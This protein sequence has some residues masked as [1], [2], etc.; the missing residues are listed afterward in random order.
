[1]NENAMILSA[2]ENRLKSRLSL[3]HHANKSSRQSG[4]L[5]LRP[6]LSDPAV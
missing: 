5:L 3:I 2:F 4:T 6:G 1:M